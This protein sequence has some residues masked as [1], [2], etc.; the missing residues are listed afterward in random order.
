LIAVEYCFQPDDKQELT[1]RFHFLVFLVLLSFYYFLFVAAAAAAVAHNPQFRVP[2]TL[3]EISNAHLRISRHTY[4]YTLELAWP[5]FPQIFHI[6]I[7]FYDLFFFFGYALISHQT[8]KKKKK[9]GLYTLFIEVCVLFFLAFHVFFS[10]PFF[11]KLILK[12]SHCIIA[13]GNL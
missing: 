1:K 5:T 3:K 8:N 12:Y 2:N 7:I 9:D 6:S 10:F 11:R 4:I 13:C